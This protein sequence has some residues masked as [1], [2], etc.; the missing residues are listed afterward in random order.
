MVDLPRLQPRQRFER[1][2]S[3]SDLES[4][5]VC[6]VPLNH[7]NFGS[8]AS[9]TVPGSLTGDLGSGIRLSV[10]VLVAGTWGILH[11]ATL[12]GFRR[13]AIL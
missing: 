6:C 3:A 12:G 8:S 2:S 7:R 1:V 10:L 9:Q 11:T 5:W 13:E 4:H